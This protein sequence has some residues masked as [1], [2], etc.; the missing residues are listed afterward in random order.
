MAMLCALVTLTLISLTSTT[1]IQDNVVFQKTNDITTT[2]SRW[3]VTMITDFKPFDNFI[4]DVGSKIITAEGLAYQLVRN[5]GSPEHAGFLNAFQGLRTEIQNIRDMIV[6]ILTSSEDIRKLQGHRHKR[7][8]LPIMGKVLSLLFGTVSE[9]DLDG[10]RDNIVIL[11]QNQQDI[12]HVVEKSL[13]VINTSKI[14]ISENRHAINKLIT[15]AHTID[16]K[17]TNITRLLR[18]DIKQVE[19]FLRQYLHLDLI[20]QELRQLMQQ[21]VAYLEHINLQLN[22][23]SLGHL[24]PSV[25]SPTNLLQLLLQIKSKLPG[26]LQLPEDPE[27]QL[28]HYYKF[29]TCTAV[30]E[31]NKILTILSVPLLDYKG[32]YEIYKVHNLPLPYISSNIDPRDQPNMIAKYQV[33][34]D[35]IA[36]NAE[37][38][39]YMILN[40]GEMEHCSSPLVKFC[41]TKSPTFPINL[42]TLCVIAL[43]MSDHTKIESYCQ[44]ITQSNALIPNAMYLSEGQWIIVAQTPLTFSVVC[45]KSHDII[46]TSPPIALVKLNLTCSASNGYLTLPPYF[47]QESK[48]VIHD[49][50]EE[51]IKWTNVSLKMWAPFTQWF[52]NF[53]KASIPDEL[54]DIEPF[55]MSHFISRLHNLRNLKAMKSGWPWWVYLIIIAVV[56]SVVCVIAIFLYIKLR[57]NLFKSLSAKQKFTGSRHIRPP[58]I[59]SAVPTEVGGGENADRETLPTSLYPQLFLATS[60]GEP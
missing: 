30:I 13:T 48:K 10:I 2:R 35:M 57:T 9:S 36:V 21:A 15:A 16:N 50:L 54:R 40:S 28:W 19:H 14:E 22:M 6:T 20:A 55:P 53:T 8:L 1:F 3:L 23:L 24:S 41:D 31:K 49:S 33:E 44:R 38:T 17:L 43:F 26:Y 47:H 39:K 32:Q 51:I 45:E 42:S 59:Y 4:I 7:S 46:Q 29:L 56:I 5:Y 18:Q 60:P 37:R 12:V 11:Q 25:I 58:P 34:T 52:P 27:E